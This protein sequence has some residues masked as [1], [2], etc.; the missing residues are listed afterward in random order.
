MQSPVSTILRRVLDQVRDNRDGEMAGYLP[1]YAA[2]DPELLGIALTSTDGHIYA[3]GD[4]N[5]PFWIQSISKPLTY[6]LALADQGMDAVDAKIDI[7]PSGD[8]YNEISL[9]PETHKPRNPMINAGAIAAAELVGGATSEER[10]ERLRAHF[11]AYAARDLYS[12]DS[13][14]EQEMASGHRNRAIGNLLRWGGIISDEQAALE[15]YT[16]G[17]T[18][19]VDCRD[20]SVMAA[21]LANGG[22]N[23]ITGEPVLEPHLVER[24]LSVMTTTG[25]YDG[26]GNW[27]A[28]V[29]MP[30]KSGVG[31]AIIAVLP[32]QVG[33]A[34]YSPRLDRHGNSV[35]GMAASRLVSSELELHFMHVGR[36]ARSAL[37]A[38]YDIAEAPSLQRRTSA[39]LCVLDKVGHHARVF[40][41]HGDLQFAEAERVVRAVLEPGNELELAVLDL[42]RVDEI[43]GV[44]RRMLDDLLSQLR[45]AGGD[46]VTVDPDGLL[47]D[48][49]TT[50]FRTRD[51][52]VAWCED[53]LIDRHGNPGMRPSHMSI[54]D[55]PFLA[56]LDQS[57]LDWLSPLLEL[58]HYPSGEQILE[59]GKPSRGI[60]LILS[61]LVI[62]SSTEGSEGAGSHRITTLAAGMSI[63]ERALSSE[64]LQ[65]ADAVA[66]GPVDIALLPAEQLRRLEDEY[67]EIAVSLWRK[68]ARDAHRTLW[69]YASE[70]AARNASSA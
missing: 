45:A 41:L 61:G 65:N 1:E 35:R 8:A 17:C 31:G 48:D 33:M 44:A 68:I 36:G 50:T 3:E 5:E 54:T 63:G 66:H 25:M 27:V 19:R 47:S 39:E 38:S 57:A 12:Q 32:G 43:T 6:G 69:H 53:W 59:V 23:P 62:V 13:V 70:V 37:R 22:V 60:Y 51:G 42:R 2:I 46:A 40:E 64:Q 30:A 20:L 34:V 26:A 10:F 67:P 9:D 28:Q 21:T 55:H 4:T 56:D 7:E 24:V 52:A 11:S 15:V 29:G 16:R 18:V 49:T 14:Y 58:R